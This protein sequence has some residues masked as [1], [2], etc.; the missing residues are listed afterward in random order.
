M[1]YTVSASTSVLQNMIKLAEIEISYPDLSF[2]V[3]KCGVVRV[4]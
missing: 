2:S 3:S 4:G 1:K